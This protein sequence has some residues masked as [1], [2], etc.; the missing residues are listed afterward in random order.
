MAT[1]KKGRRSSRKRHFCALA[2]MCADEKVIEFNIRMRR[3][4]SR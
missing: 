1:T 2:G 3:W 4:R